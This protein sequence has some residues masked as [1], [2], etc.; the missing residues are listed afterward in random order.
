MLATVLF[1]YSS[2]K[3]SISQS[4]YSD[5]DSLVSSNKAL[6]EKLLIDGYEKNELVKVL[7]PIFN[8]EIIIGKTGFLFCIDTLGE[9]IIH[10]KVQGENWKDVEFIKVILEQKQ[11]F[12]RYISPKTKTWKIA[13][14]S[15]ISGTDMIIVAAAFEEDFLK[16][17]LERIIRTMVI[18][19]AL[20]IASGVA[21]ASFMIHQQIK[22]PLDNI[23][24][25][26]K[27][28]TEEADLSHRFIDKRKSHDEIFILYKGLDDF[29][30]RLKS[31]LE[32][33]KISSDHTRER[34]DD[35]VGKTALMNTSIE[36]IVSQLDKKKQ[37][38][39]HM[40][41]AVNTCHEGTQIINERIGSLSDSI[42]DQTAMVEES[43][44]AIRE[45]LATV[46][47]ITTIMGEQS[48]AVEAV[49][50]TIIHGRDKI[51]EST[52]A[53]H[54]I[55]GSADDI[56]STIEIISTIANKTNLLAM[57]AA[58]EAAHAG[59]AGYGFAVVA[60][61]IRKL[62]YSANENSEIIGKSINS[63]MD[64]IELNSQLSQDTATVFNKIEKEVK[65]ITL[66]IHETANS[67]KE[68]KTG[69]EQ[70]SLAVTKLQ[71]ISGEVNRTGKDI[72][73]HTNDSALLMD[74]LQKITTTLTDAMK[75]I[76][77][78]SEKISANI[79]SLT[80]E[81]NEVSEGAEKVSQAISIF[82][83]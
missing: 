56:K 24:K 36:E 28:L 40:S 58:I 9:L 59:K 8:E 78:L 7:E 18:V 64:K 75:I 22:Y 2:F 10:K 32:M 62:A 47:S 67:L 13:S 71:D 1:L 3:Q 66:W 17:P 55:L 48:R 44:A 4:V 68:M 12:Y 34:K 50:S 73:N 63:V 35:M 5:L 57:N 29:I 61:E 52:A 43:S 69:G 15:R 11:G 51:Q 60:D 19:F 39:N 16:D 14:F 72:S 45:M 21:Y 83:L 81:V 37:I 27:K 6:A 65:N 49:E 80:E 25:D 26:T 53:A 74:E 20:S 77:Q 33:I 31:I 82:K 42:T 23:V 46:D 38:V 54:E 70:I 30:R 76:A 41:G 79:T